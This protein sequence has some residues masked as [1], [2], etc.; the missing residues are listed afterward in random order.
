MSMLQKIFSTAVLLNSICMATPLFSSTINKQDNASSPLVL[1][2][3]K[4]NP[5][6]EVEL[7]CW[8]AK[9]EGNDFAVTGSAITVPGTT[10]PNTSLTPASFTTA[11]EVYAPGPSIRPGFRVGLGVNLAQ[12]GWDLIGE[13]TYFHGK[14]SQSISSTDIN[15]GLLPIFSY[16]P[17]NSILSQATFFAATGATG[18]VADASSS[19]HLN[20]NNITLE[21]G[22]ESAINEWLSLHHHFGLQ[23][24]W[25]TQDTTTT[26]QVNSFSNLSSVLGNNKILFHQNSWGIGLRYGLDT[27]WKCRN[28]LGVFANGA[29]AALWGQFK[30]QASSYDTN[31]SEGYEN[32]LISNQTNNLYTISPV[33]QFAIGLQTDWVFKTTYR[34]LAQAGW[35]EQIWFFQNQHSS[36]I[37][38]TSLLLQG[39]TVKFRFDF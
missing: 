7:L 31:V 33:L 19:W 13:Y 18:F 25:Q 38:N 35:E 23:G 37:A 27:V 20:F 8:W 16:T 24:S 32:V 17:H 4:N 3:H 28:H 9:Q 14:A 30:A 11:G 6:F 1:P 5:L 10:D 26:Y 34:F 12:G 2:Q 36:S 22:K 21:L 15:T 39:L 29:L